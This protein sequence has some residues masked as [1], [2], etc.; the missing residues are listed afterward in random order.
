MNATQALETCSLR[1]YKAEGSNFIGQ[2]SK[3]L[4]EKPV[5]KVWKCLFTACSN[6]LSESTY[7]DFS[8]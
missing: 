4:L 2:H 5:C 3:C 8:Q 1:E 6:H 7:E